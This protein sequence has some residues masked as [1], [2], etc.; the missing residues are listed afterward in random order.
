MRDPNLPQEEIEL[1]PTAKLPTPRPF[2]KAIDPNAETRDNVPAVSRELA[3]ET[4]SPHPASDE[5]PTAPLL[6]AVSPQDTD[7]IPAIPYEATID[8]TLGAAASSSP[9]I[10]ENPTVLLSVVPAPEGAER[11]RAPR[12]IVRVDVDL[13]T[14]STF[15]RAQSAD[16]SEGG[17][18]VCTTEMHPIGTR[19]ELV[20]RLPKS[21]PLFVRGSVRW[22]RPQ[23][24][25]G[26][27]RGMGISFENI[28]DEALTEIVAFIAKRP[29][30]EV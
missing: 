2:A 11:R 18:F 28:E 24:S 22:S 6:R 27:P 17:V 29:P 5:Y 12:V 14:Q 26:S 4:T 7:R 13:K 25:L 1:A 19:V 8:E 30:L 21:R 20:L 10:D 3:Y 23:G 9:A 15:F 16:I